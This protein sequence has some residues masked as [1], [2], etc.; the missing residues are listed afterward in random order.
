MKKIR[1]NFV[2]SVVAASLALAG[3][4]AEPAA[5]TPTGAQTDGHFRK[6]ILVADEQVNGKYEDT[7]KDPMELAVAADGRV[8]FAQRNGVIKVW[9]P[10]TK[11]TVEIA[12]VPVFD[13]LEDGMLGI[14]LDP[15]FLKN[16][17]I[18][19]NHSLPE[20]TMDAKG[21]KAGIIRVSRYTVT[22]DKLDLASE[23]SLLDIATQREECCHVGGSLA[24]DAKGNLY[25]S[26]L[27][28]TSPSPRDS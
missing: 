1:F 16:G 4:A 13:G 22:G 18:Y 27:L 8:F 24:F 26:C 6:V 2:R 21:K 12:K 17:W 20:T 10:D 9:K 5:P 15:N 11:T 19:L 14:T 25:I 7:L 23:K 28:Y 3:V